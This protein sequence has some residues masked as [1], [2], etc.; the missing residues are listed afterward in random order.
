MNGTGLNGRQIKSLSASCQCGKVVLEAAFA[1]ILVA[2]CY[3]T[4]CQRAGHAFEKMASAA[5]VLDADGGTAFIVYRKDRIR[6]VRGRE[7]LREFRLTPNS[8][9]RRVVATCCHSAMFLDFTKGHW[10]SLYRSRF[11]AAA[12]PVQMRIMTSERRDDVVLGRD[13]PN[14]RGRPPSFAWQLIATW[15][16]MGF[17][18]PDMGLAHLP[19]S[20]FDGG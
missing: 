15:V 17:R 2:S 13:L 4:S 5:P 16:A 6:C 18:I 10:L 12:P 9:T 1:P 8:P 14:Y 7:L 11:G 20:S 19:Q 3:C